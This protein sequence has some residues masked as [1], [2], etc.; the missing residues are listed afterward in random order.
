MQPALR[1][2]YTI[3]YREFIRF[4]R[5]RSR[6]IGMIGQPLLYLLIVGQ[7]ISAAMGFRGV[8]ANIPVNYVQFMYPGILGMSVLFTSI[9]SGVS[10][11]WDREFGFLK[12]VLVAPVPRWATA[13]GKALGG[14]TVAIV[15]AAIMLFLAPFVKVSLTPLMILQ[16]L[17]TL[18]LISLALTFFGI[19]IA[20]RMETMEGFQMIMNFLIMPLFF[21]SGAIFPMTNLPGWM[22]FLMKIDPLTYGVD[23]LR[24]LIYAGADPR[25]L[26]FLVHYSLGFDLTVIT[27]MVLILGFL[28]SWSFSRQE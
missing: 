1:A 13:L 24:R 11:I 15:Q 9:F 18:F 16:L 28:G 4:I 3:W 21:L 7:G 27:A 25:V 23:A 19:A 2:I 20:S 14:S 6:L 22:N 10:I 17:G 12:E 8:P 5:E 26:E